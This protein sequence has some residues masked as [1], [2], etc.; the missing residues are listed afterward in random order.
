MKRIYLIILLGLLACKANNPNVVANFPEDPE[1]KRMNRNGKMFS[2]I[3]LLQNK[4]NKKIDNKEEEKRENLWK[5]SFKVVSQILPISIA[6]EESGLIVSDWGNVKN[7]INFY[8][9]NIVITGSDFNK[10]NITL[11]AFKKLNN[12]KTIEDKELEEKLLNM[13]FNKTLN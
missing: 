5:K 9:I 1:L 6:D 7:D 10:D 13:I 11:T 8:K 12:Q 3:V 4:D 2:D